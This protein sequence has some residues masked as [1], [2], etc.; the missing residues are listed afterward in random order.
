M[1]QEWHPFSITGPYDGADIYIKAVGDW[2][3]SICALGQSY[4]QV[5]VRVDGPYGIASL[6]CPIGH[7]SI[8]SSC[9]YLS[10]HNTA[11]LLIGGGVGIVPWADIVVEGARPLIHWSSVTVVWV[12]RGN[13]EYEA[14]ELNLQLHQRRDPQVQIQVYITGGDADTIAPP[15]VIVSQTAPCL[16]RSFSIATL[17]RTRFV[18]ALLP[19]IVFYVSICMSDRI[20]EACSPSTSWKRGVF[21][22]SLA[23]HGSQLPL[24]LATMAFAAAL[25]ALCLHILQRFSA[26]CSR[27]LKLLNGS[28]HHACQAREITK[29]RLLRSAEGGQ[30]HWYSISHGRPDIKQV[31]HSYAEEQALSVKVCGPLPVVN[32]ARQAVAEAASSG[33]SLSLEIEDAEW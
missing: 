6:Q 24:A 32:A 2:S 28:P 14:L 29:S 12:V 30:D 9:P 3:S 16:Y 18:M 8:A 19:T 20:K 10:S 26:R 5:N 17:L 33:R 11:L 1:S 22:Y 23:T 7:P 27:Y 15:P 25:L 21:L 13:A 4:Q 31:I